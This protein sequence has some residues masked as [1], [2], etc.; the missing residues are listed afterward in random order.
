MPTISKS[1]FKD[2][3]PDDFNFRGLQVTMRAN[4]FPKKSMPEEEEV[5]DLRKAKQKKGPPTYQSMIK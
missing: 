2:I 3:S 5:L 4:T 1:K